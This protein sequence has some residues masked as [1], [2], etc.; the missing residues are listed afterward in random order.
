M[1]FN[2]FTYL[3][4]LSRTLRFELIPIGK[5]KKLVEMENAFLKDK[6]ILKNYK[7]TK[8]YLDKLHR[9]FINDA[10]KQCQIDFTDYFNL[11]KQKKENNSKNDLKKEED[12]LRKEISSYFKTDDRGKRKY[13]YLIYKNLFEKEIFEIL[14]E[15]FP[16]KQK[17][18]AAFDKFSTYFTNYH[19]SKKN[20]YTD[21]AQTTAIAHRIVN[22][23][24]PRF[25]SNLKIYKDE[26]QKLKLTSEEKQTFS[27][28]YYNECLTQSGIEEYNRI[29][30]L[31]NIKVNQFRQN[32]KTKIPFLKLLFK[33]ILAES[34][35]EQEKFIE[36]KS[37]NEVFPVLKEFISHLQLNIYQAKKIFSDFIHNQNGIDID[38]IYLAGRSVNT[39]SNKWFSS[40]LM[41]G[42][43]LPKNSS[44]KKVKDFISFKEI[45][46]IL[47]SKEN[48]KISQEVLFS[49]EYLEKKIIDKNKSHYE[50]FL[51]IWTY[52][53]NNLIKSYEQNL[54]KTKKM[55]E[56][57][58]KYTNK[59]GKLENGEKGEAQKEV[60]K[61]YSDSALTIYQIM[62]YFSL[63][64]KRQWNPD[65]LNEDADFYNPYT[66]YYQNDNTWKYY[67]ELRNYL[68]KKP[69]FNE[70]IKL[71]FDNSTLLNGW[72][73]NKEIANY[74]VILRKNRI[75]YL[76]I[77]KPQNNKIFSEK[78]LI[79]NKSGD[80]YEKMVYKFLPDPKKDLPHICFSKRNRTLFQPSDKIIDIKDKE[81][82][83]IKTSH[84]SLEAM[85]AMIDFYK[86]ALTLY[87]DWQIFNFEHLKP[88]SNYQTNI[89]EFY[90]D[91]E[92]N[93]YKVWF[94]KID[95]EYINK[96]VENEELYLFQIYNKDWAKGKN[97]KS[98]KN[99][100][101][102]YWENL[103]SQENL[104]KPLFKL[105]GQ[106]EVFFRKASLKKEIEKRKK[107]DIIKYKRYT[108]DKIFFHCPI[109]LNFSFPKKTNL[110]PLINE[111]IS[112]SDKFRIIGIDRGEKNLLYLSAIDDKGNLLSGLTKSL[113]VINGVDYQAKLDV[114]EKQRDK[115]RKSWQTI[116]K[117]RDMKMGYISQA[118]NEVT[119]IIFQSLD[120]GDLPLI[121]FEN[122]SIGFKRGR[123]K[124]EKQVYQN[125]ELALAKK[126]NYLVSKEKNNLRDAYQLTPL[127]QNYQDIGR[128][129]G[130][131]FYV[132]ASFTSAICPKCG[133]R[134]R[135][136]ELTFKSIGQIKKY[137]EDHEFKIIHDGEKFIFNCFASQENIAKKENPNE[138]FHDKLPDNNLKFNS[139]GERLRYKKNKNS[140]DGQIIS[141]NP[142]QLLFELFINQKI[143]L[144]KEIKKQMIN[145]NF[146]Q[147]FYK[148]FIFYLSL[149]LQLRNS[150]SEKNID[151]ISCPACG[152]HSDQNF[153][154]QTWNGDANGAY[155]IA[156]K[157]LLV[158]EK[159]KQSC[160]KKPA[161]KIKYDD[162]KVTMTEWDKFLAQKGKG[163]G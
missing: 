147:E 56:Q 151:Y 142:T 108:D 40:W 141:Y 87:P 18:F 21:K 88:T 42:G 48:Q 23:N 44:G 119:K 9:E 122:L 129:Y 110:N 121:V 76:G 103:F 13:G 96:K 67:N 152:F 38:K 135:L 7:E 80:N 68:T 22:E 117:I 97:K 36:I 43:L 28:N 128:Q 31:I 5:T 107:R 54:E 93:S 34:A 63:E 12:K 111:F 156:R 49:S 82:F 143:D 102:L 79:K 155:N 100:H 71:N 72:D 99:L 32:T 78:Y 124:I 65:N 136:Y 161:D 62:K 73:K 91:I 46:N 130:I 120:E 95:A 116:H 94:E 53:F 35:T 74:C 27:L 109:T 115:E 157:G 57:D 60:I 45:R 90:Q 104:I 39:I 159:I 37:N 11:Y 52:E 114:L 125:F 41:F 4:E 126:L 158:V 17:I 15:K 140:R 132:P 92:K 89:G 146:T 137:L 2:Q 112:K 145:G 163:N 139:L 98:K 6:T 144:G 150:D 83:K 154:G 55:I 101:T 30:G 75:Y 70:K 69:F 81:K 59:K 10:L 26:C 84:F 153:R 24:L 1:V 58:E 123:F 118:V 77:M 66:Q 61:N 16:E 127:V 149:I 47:E 131:I 162:L 29:V 138:I 160:G 20:L 148:S 64:K 51:K 85:Q 25:C 106:A 105:N 33:Q 3:Y 19:Q 50:N 86:K 8:T 134:K 113:N 14:K 133:F